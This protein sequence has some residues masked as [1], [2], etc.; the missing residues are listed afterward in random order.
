MSS[1][2]SARDERKS[3]RGTNLFLWNFDHNDR[4]DKHSR[5]KTASGLVFVVF[6][7]LS[8]WYLHR[9][10]GFQSERTNKIHKVRLNA[11]VNC[12][13]QQ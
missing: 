4:T 2:A 10:S 13:Y 6:D 7:A 5:L 12:C 3:L 1:Y 11:F 9:L 8:N